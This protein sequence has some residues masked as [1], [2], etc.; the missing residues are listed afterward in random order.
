MKIQ[1][2]SDL[3][4]EFREN[5]ELINRNPLL[6]RAEILLLAG[7]IVPFSEIA[8]NKDFFNYLSDHFLLTYWVPGNHEYYFSDISERSG[9]LTEKIRDNVLLVNNISVQ[10]NDVKIIFSTLWSKIELGNE[11]RIAGSISDFKVIKFNGNFFSVSNFN[12]LHSACLKFIESEL[13]RHYAGKTVVVTH[14]VPTFLNYP[15]KYKGSILNEAFVVELFSL[16]ESSKIDYWIYGHHHN[17]TPDFQIGNTVLLTNQMG[18][19]REGE[20]QHFKRDRI[21]TL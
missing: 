2:C 7:D 11:W 19:V 5:K 14:H 15:T 16:I 3:H 1:Y 18:Y 21:I 8:R 10:V 9:Q 12:G 6:P 17:N 4:L 13:D 20:N